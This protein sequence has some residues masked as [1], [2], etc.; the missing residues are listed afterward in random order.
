MAKRRNHSDTMMVRNLGDAVKLI[1]H[2]TKALEHTITKVAKNARGAKAFGVVALCYA[3]Y[4]AA[5]CRQMEEEQYKLS[6]RVQKL[7]NK[8]GE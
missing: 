3:A 7:E 6:I 5:K 8:E 1:N 4:T 2:N